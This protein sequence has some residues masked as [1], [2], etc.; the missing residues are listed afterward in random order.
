MR[1]DEVEWVPYH[2]CDQSSDDDSYFW[3]KFREL[4]STE[5]FSFSK[6]RS[7]TRKK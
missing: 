6:T 5:N 2:D 7:M 4:I 3:V 1:R